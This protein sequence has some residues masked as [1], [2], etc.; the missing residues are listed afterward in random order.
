M[1]RNHFDD[2]SEEFKRF[3]QKMILKMRKQSMIEKK[4]I[5]SQNY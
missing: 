5:K 4:N 3:Y 1:F 2:Y